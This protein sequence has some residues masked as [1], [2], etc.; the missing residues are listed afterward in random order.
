MAHVIENCT[1]KVAQLFD[2]CTHV[3]HVIDNCTRQ[4]AHVIDH[5]TCTRQVAEVI[6]DYKRQI[7]Y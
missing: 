6:D 7:H 2:H 5:C 3:A 1:R 4:V